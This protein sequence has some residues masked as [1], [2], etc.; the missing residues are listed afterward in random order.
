MKEQVGPRVA[1]ATLLTIAAPYFLI[2]LIFLSLVTS[3]AALHHDAEEGREITRMGRHTGCAE[4]LHDWR[5][6]AGNAIKHGAAHPGK[7]FDRKG[8]G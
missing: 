3:T 6:S 4:R 2:D 1:R 5:C 7:S 8:L